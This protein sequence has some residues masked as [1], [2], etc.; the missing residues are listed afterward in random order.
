MLLRLTIS[1]SFNIFY[2]KQHL[3]MRFLTYL[4]LLLYERQDQ[5]SSVAGRELGPWQEM[6]EV[7]RLKPDNR[8][9]TLA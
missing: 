2:F 4:V 8:P 3:R 9:L 5:D 6:K 1:T 7:L